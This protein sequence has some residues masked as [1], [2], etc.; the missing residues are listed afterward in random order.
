MRALLSCL[1][2]SLADAAP[3]RARLGVERLENT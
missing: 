2:L 1:L 3:K